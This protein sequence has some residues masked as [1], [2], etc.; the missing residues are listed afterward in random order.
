MINIKSLACILL[1]G[2]LWGPSFFFIKIALEGGMPPF[3]LAFIRVAMA[4]IFLWL[5]LGL[6][7]IALPTSP[8]IYLHTAVIAIFSLALPFCLINIA[9]QYIDSAL[10]G[11][12]NGL[13]PIATTL[14]AHLLIHDEKLTMNRIIG[15]ILGVCGFLLLLLPTLFTKEIIADPLS[16]I[17]VAIAAI[18][19]A[20]GIIYGRMFLH[21]T[22][23][24]ALPTL[25]VSFAALYLL[26]FSLGID[27]ISYISHIT[28][29]AWTSVILLAFLG[30]ACAFVVY[31]YVLQQY[32]AIALGTSVFL[33]P[34]FAIF[35]GVLFLGE[36]LT[37]LTC[38]STLLILSGMKLVIKQE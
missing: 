28:P 17:G 15:I 20:M 32:G 38:A 25:Q 4:A 6:R 36:Q 10:A 7:S 37:W 2:V 3:S 35:F 31:F 24:L 1:L 30:T 14:L 13:T 18:S 33:L 27:G 29:E 12:I 21:T 9:E 5:L 8:K 16:I 23:T 22:R 26:P 11:I 19:Y 34:I